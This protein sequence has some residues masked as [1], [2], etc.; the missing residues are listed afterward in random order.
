MAQNNPLGFNRSKPQTLIRTAPPRTPQP[1]FTQT[2]RAV[3][4]QAP[5]QS[6][7]VEAR[8]PTSFQPQPASIH[9]AAPSR[10]RVL[11]RSPTSSNA[12]ANAI[13]QQFKQDTKYTHTSQ[14]DPSASQMNSASN[15]FY[16]T[17]FPNSNSNQSQPQV[18]VSPSAGGMSAGTIKGI[19]DILQKFEKNQ[20]DKI[21]KL[22]SML[23]TLKS[24]LAADRNSFLMTISKLKAT[25]E[26]TNKHEHDFKS[27]YEFWNN[28]LKKV[29][30][31]DDLSK[32]I[33]ESD[34][35][36]NEKLLKTSEYF[37]GLHETVSQQTTISAICFH[38][39]VPIFC[40]PSRES[41]ILGSCS[42]GEEVKFRL[43]MIEQDDGIWVELQRVDDIGTVLKG[44]VVVYGSR[45]PS[46]DEPKDSDDYPGIIHT[47]VDSIQKS[48]S[49]LVPYFGE[50]TM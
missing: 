9:A 31:K 49:N 14:Q 50:F 21:Q 8:P 19:L 27:A 42:K 48:E 13:G 29:V 23:E 34:D 32:V 38:E 12:H 6:S 47:C 15:S 43:P 18:D 1:Q 26:M 10:L 5:N 35:R 39:N 4:N 36:T 25:E 3:P 17:S 41:S 24:S 20:N 30:T 22:E 2:P 44:Y 33:Q 46:V 16:P 28:Q 37:V 11:N 45:L 7:L 40:D